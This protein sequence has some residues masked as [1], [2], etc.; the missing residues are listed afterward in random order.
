M[1]STEGRRATLDVTVAGDDV[2]VSYAHQTTETEDTAAV[3]AAVRRC[4]IE[5]DEDGGI[6]HDRDRSR[7][8]NPRV[9]HFVE[10]TE[11]VSGP[12]GGDSNQEEIVDDDEDGSVDH[13]GMRL[14]VGGSDSMRRVDDEEE[15][16]EGEGAGM[17]EG[18]T[19][20]WGRAGG[21]EEVARILWERFLD[22]KEEGVDYR[23]VDAD[24]RMDDLD[25]LAQDEVS[26]F[27]LQ[28]VVAFAGKVC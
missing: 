24:E 27:R 28:N 20:A 21:R 16:E 10:H 22:G 12:N 13:D 18:G 2:D 19:A 14:H 26:P 23:A 4:S 15:E 3:T 1:S 6:S 17:E 5:G 7:K 8:N 25:Q 11:A 9:V